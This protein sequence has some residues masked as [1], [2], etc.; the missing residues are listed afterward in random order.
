MIICSFSWKYTVRHV[1]IEWD[2][3]KGNYAALT[4]GAT[5][6]RY[7]RYVN[8]FFSFYI[9]KGK[10]FKRQNISKFN[11]ITVTC[12]LNHCNLKW[13]NGCRVSYGFG[14]V[15]LLPLAC[16]VFYIYSSAHFVFRTHLSFHPLICTFCFCFFSSAFVFIFSRIKIPL[17]DSDCGRF[18]FQNKK[19]PWSSPIS[20]LRRFYFFFAHNY[21]IVA[22]NA[23]LFLAW[24]LTKFFP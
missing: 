24:S 20:V 2:E 22:I 1:P 12:N 11:M 4:V 8:A 10:K 19:C 5:Q 17:S 18:T 23:Y 9:C 21:D 3:E 7:P 6:C 14:L 15:L 16:H 13:L